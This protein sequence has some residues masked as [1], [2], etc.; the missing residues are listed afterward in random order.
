MKNTFSFNDESKKGASISILIVFG[1]TN[2]LVLVAC[3]VPVIPLFALIMPLCLNIFNTDKT[4]VP[5]PIVD[6]IDTDF[7]ILET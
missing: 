2:P 3:A 6:P 1:Y 4:S 7:G 5:I